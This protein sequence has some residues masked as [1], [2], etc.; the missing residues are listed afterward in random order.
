LAAEVNCNRI[1]FQRGTHTRWQQVAND[2]TGAPTLIDMR[3]SFVD[4]TGGVL[5]LSIAAPPNFSRVRV[6]V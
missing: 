3:T 4:A 2:G 6:R 1:G 5:I